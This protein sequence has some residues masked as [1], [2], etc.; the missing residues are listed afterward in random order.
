MCTGY[1]NH[2]FLEHQGRSDDVVLNVQDSYQF[3]VQYLAILSQ[4]SCRKFGVSSPQSPTE[5][6]IPREEILSK[7]ITIL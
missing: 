6:I 7:N 1:C 4:F 5:M 3:A 2:H